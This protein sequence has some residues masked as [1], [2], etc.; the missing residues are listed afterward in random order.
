M[1]QVTD[2]CNDL[3]VL[4]I[5]TSRIASRFRVGVVSIVLFL[6]APIFL[7]FFVPNP[8]LISSR[9]LPATLFQRPLAR[10]VS[11]I[12]VKSINVVL[13]QILFERHAVLCVPCRSYLCSAYLI[14]LLRLQ[15]T[16]YETAGETSVI[17]SRDCRLRHAG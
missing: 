2:R 3:R 7:G 16:S 13:K 11:T 5:S 12:P 1:P 15:T 4:G 17:N 6:T 9:C 14:K 10:N 8:Y